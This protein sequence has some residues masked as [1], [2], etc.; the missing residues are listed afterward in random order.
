MH[1]N[2]SIKRIEF[3]SSNRFHELVPGQHPTGTLGQGHQ[4]IE[5]VRGQVADLGPQ[6]H[7]AGITVNLQLTKA[8]LVARL[9]RTVNPAPQDGPDAPQ[10]LPHHIGQAGIV[11]DH[12]KVLAH[13]LSLGPGHPLLFKHS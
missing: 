4:Q 3:A 9:D 12:Q 11:L 2:R 7:C 8:Q 10:V 6:M 1:I 5:L 13:A